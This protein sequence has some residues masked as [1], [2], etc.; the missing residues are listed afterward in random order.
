M[1]RLWYTA[2]TGDNRASNFGKSVYWFDSAE[3]DLEIAHAMPEPRRLLYVGFMC[4]RTI[5]KC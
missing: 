2:L 3:Y 5:K 4:H 1:S